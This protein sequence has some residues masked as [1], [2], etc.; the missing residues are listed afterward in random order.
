MTEAHKEDS[1]TRAWCHC[2]PGQIPFH[3]HFTFLPATVAHSAA[4]SDHKRAGCSQQGL[5]NS[6]EIGNPRQAPGAERKI[7]ASWAP[8]AQDLQLSQYWMMLAFLYIHVSSNLRLQPPTF[9]FMGVQFPCAS[10]GFMKFHSEY[11]WIIQDNSSPKESLSHP[12]N[13]HFSK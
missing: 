4:R 5:V 12:Q 8:P 11:K 10:L 7:G 6:L 13:P 1:C 3:F 2:R 9:S